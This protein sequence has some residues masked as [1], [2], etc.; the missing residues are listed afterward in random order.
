MQAPCITTHFVDMSISAGLQNKSEFSI[1]FFASLRSKNIVFSGHLLQKG[2]NLS[3][4]KNTIPPN[5][6]R[7]AQSKKDSGFYYHYSWSAL[8]NIWS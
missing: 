4:L 7:T 8:L 3:C 6:M 5:Y 2:I 1:D